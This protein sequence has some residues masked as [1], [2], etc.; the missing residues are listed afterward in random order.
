MSCVAVTAVDTLYC[1]FL[2]GSSRF[3]SL[4]LLIWC[5]RAKYGNKLIQTA[6]Y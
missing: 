4:N 3:E 5:Q 2:L 1:V 6:I